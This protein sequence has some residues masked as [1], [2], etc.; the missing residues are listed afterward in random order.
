MKT[1]QEERIKY[2][3]QYPFRE[4]DV[5]SWVDVVDGTRKGG[6]IQQINPVYAE[7]TVGEDDVDTQILLENSLNQESMASLAGDSPL[8]WEADINCDDGHTYS[9][10]VSD[11]KKE[12]L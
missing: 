9:I 11:L 3:A 1:W 8:F 7:I 12:V 4:G 6:V 5:V 10:K 2:E